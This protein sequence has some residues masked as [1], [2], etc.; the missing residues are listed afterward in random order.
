MSLADIVF[1]VVG[2]FFLFLIIQK[3]LFHKKKKVSPSP[4]T[5]SVEPLPS[6]FPQRP[7]VS[8][9]SRDAEPYVPQTQTQNYAPLQ[10]NP[11]PYSPP[12]NPAYDRIGS[13]A[14]P[15]SSFVIEQAMLDMEEQEIFFEEE[16]EEERFEG[17]AD[18][19]EFS[20]SNSNDYN[21]DNSNF[22]DNTSYDTSNDNT[23]Y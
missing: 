14:T 13:P 4:A 5:M 10:G 17:Q 18:R 23:N 2:L 3:I 16:T 19:E 9:S 15:S 6:V 21:N 20:D 7:Y 8:E 1:L 11:R 22:N 12:Y